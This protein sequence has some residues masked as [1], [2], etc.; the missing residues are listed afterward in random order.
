MIGALLFAMV[1]FYPSQPFEFSLDILMRPLLNLGIALVLFV[2][3]VSALARFLP[4]LP[5]FNRLILATQ[6]ASGPSTE[7]TTPAFFEPRVRVG[8][9]GVARTILRPA[10]KAEFGAA[11][12]DVVTDGEFVERGAKV[13]VAMVEG[14]RVV[15]EA[16]NGGGPAAA[17]DPLPVSY[18]RISRNAPTSE[19]TIISHSK[20]D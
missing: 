4:N 11:L 16:A 8:E 1:D 14:D 15:V 20:T 3:A 13:R 12:V 9:D 17:H 19:K 7:N 6:S 5:F 18:V 2:F 10:G